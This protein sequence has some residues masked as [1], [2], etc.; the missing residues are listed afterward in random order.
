[1]KERTMKD[2][3]ASF[4]KW[5]KDHYVDL[6][7]LDKIDWVGEYDFKL[8]ISENIEGFKQKF[9]TMFKKTD[10][11]IGKELKA[12]IEKEEFDKLEKFKEEEEETLKNFKAQKPSHIQVEGFENAKHLILMTAQKFTNSTIIFGEGGLGKTLLTLN[13]LKTTLQPTEWIYRNGYTTPLSL[14]KTLYN[15]V[16]K[17]IVLDDVEGGLFG[18]EKAVSL[19]KSAM[20]DSDGKRLVYYESSSKHS[21]EIPSPFEFRGRLIILCNRIANKDNP[22]VRALLTRGMT[23]ELTFTYKQKL[24]IITQILEDNKQLS[25]EKKEKI[26]RIISERTNIATENFNFRTLQKLI[27]MVNYDIER[28]EL[29]FK[30]T[31]TEDTLKAL[32]WKIIN[33]PLVKGRQNQVKL[34]LEECIKLGIQGS[35]ATF[36]RRLKEIKD[37][38]LKEKRLAKAGGKI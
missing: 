38:I 37:E 25:A 5:V 10:T 21:Q 27:A 24:K 11:E 16:D 9:P 20:W 23:Y 26:K 18:D 30:A 35:R 31:T 29:L 32:V 1:M 3:P 28:A 34:F 4:K 2:I 36:Y 17:V 15:N 12:Q 33:D 19:L 7:G 14:V 13:T 22:N 6:N 8:D